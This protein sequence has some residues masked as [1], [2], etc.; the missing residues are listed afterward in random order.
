MNEGWKERTA[1]S[2]SYLTSLRGC[3]ALKAVLA[4]IVMVQL[5]VSKL[6]G[7]V[8]DRCV[9]LRNGPKDVFFCWEKEA[10]VSERLAAEA[11]SRPQWKAFPG[12][13]LTCA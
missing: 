3:A 13:P 7:E 5:E 6:S 9:W 2:N 10:Q 12:R 1:S 11:R 8:I 4:N